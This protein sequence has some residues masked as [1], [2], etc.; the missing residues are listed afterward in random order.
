MAP[1]ADLGLEL[2]G[3]EMRAKRLE[4]RRRR[5]LDPAVVAVLAVLDSSTLFRPRPLHV[6]PAECPIDV[7]PIEGHR[8]A[9]AGASR[10]GDEE[11]RIPSWI[12]RQAGL[13]QRRHLLTAEPL[14]V[15][16]FLLRSLSDEEFEVRRRAHAVPV[17]DTDL[18]VVEPRQWAPGL[19][20]RR[21]GLLC[22]PDLEENGTDLFARDDIP[23]NVAETRALARRLRA[24]PHPAREATLVG[25][26]R[27]GADVTKGHLVVEERAQDLPERRVLALAGGARR[28]KCGAEIHARHPEAVEVMDEVLGVLLGLDHACESASVLRA[29]EDLEPTTLAPI[30]R[31]DSCGALHFIALSCCRSPCSTSA[32]RVVSRVTA[33]SFARLTSAGSRRTVTLTF[34]SVYSPIAIGPTSPA[35]RIRHASVPH[36]FFVGHHHTQLLSIKLRRV[37][38]RTSDARGGRVTASQVRSV[39][40]DSEPKPAVT[41][42]RIAFESTNQLG[43]AGVKE[44]E[45]LKR[46]PTD[47]G[48]ARRHCGWSHFL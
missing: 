31:R 19:L 4:C 35:E 43:R 14:I 36:S 46:G 24:Q 25:G 44:G 33:A 2:D 28:R 26:R 5:Q 27:R 22:L 11:K 23:G 16:L 48:L 15:A 17:L 40:V 6:D 30:R 32:W 20:D 1:A 12:A 45:L 47:R 39:G 13:E 3:L 7:R 34:P 37:A 8:L 41:T 38:E 18:P 29:D 21:K 10:E 42:W 9:P